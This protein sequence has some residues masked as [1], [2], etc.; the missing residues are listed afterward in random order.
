MTAKTLILGA[1]FPSVEVA[2]SNYEKQYATLA[3]K[4]IKM[5]SNSKHFIMFDQ[6]EWFY[7]TVNAFLANE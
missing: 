4:S 7:T 5:A 1:S 3:N 2:K 6:P